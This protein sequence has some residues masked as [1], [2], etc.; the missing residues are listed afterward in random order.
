[1]TNALLAQLCEHLFYCS[2]SKDLP[3]LRSFSTVNSFG[4]SRLSA[5]TI[6]LSSF[7]RYFFKYFLCIFHGS[8]SFLLHAWCHKHVPPVTVAEDSTAVMLSW[9][10]GE[11]KK[12][13]PL[14]YQEQLRH[15]SG[16]FLEVGSEYAV[17][18]ALSQPHVHGIDAT[19]L[20]VRQTRIPPLVL[21]GANVSVSM[22]VCDV[23]K[24]L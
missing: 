2:S 5:N 7:R 19:L 10:N 17:P 23:Q 14:A 3:P 9:L 16:S 24:A 4:W 22:Q 21:E 12:L 1:M 8:W 18:H 11:E 20:T 15:L 13:A 6:S